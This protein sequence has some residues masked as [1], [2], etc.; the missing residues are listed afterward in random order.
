[1]TADGLTKGSI[2]RHEPQHIM[3]GHIKINH[4]YEAW[5]CP[6]RQANVQR[7][8][9]ESKQLPALPA[10]P[11]ATPAPAPAP[12]RAQLTLSLFA[13]FSPQVASCRTH[14]E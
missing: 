10:V 12:A 7:A 8:A 6:L 9:A 5:S 4:P 11:T 2:E 13:S 3:D 1:M 14:S